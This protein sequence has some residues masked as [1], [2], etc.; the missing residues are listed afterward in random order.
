MRDVLLYTALVL[1]LFAGLTG[2]VHQERVPYSIVTEK[3]GFSYT[4][5][6]SYN[7]SVADSPPQLEVKV[8]AYK[9][10]NGTYVPYTGVFSPDDIVQMNIQFRVKSGQPC[11]DSIQLYAPVYDP[12]T[13]SVVDTLVHDTSAY[14]T[15]VCYGPWHGTHWMWWSGIDWP[16]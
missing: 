6:G 16:T 2:A 14:S 7:I 10:V 8:S 4:Q 15:S 1:L 9:L 5:N 3:D 12:D 13:Q 11:A